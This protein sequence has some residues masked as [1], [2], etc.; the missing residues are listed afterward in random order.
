MSERS[1]AIAMRYL[2]LDVRNTL[3]WHRSKLRAGGPPIQMPPSV[4][5]RII[6][7]VQRFAEMSAEELTACEQEIAA[8]EVPHE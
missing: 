2:L 1:D 7:D 8:L 5:L 4:C 3:Y 6:K